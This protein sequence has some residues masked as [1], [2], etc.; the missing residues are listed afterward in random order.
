MSQYVDA[1]RLNEAGPELSD[2]P[3]G[4]DPHV[5]PVAVAPVSRLRSPIMEH[6]L[7]TPLPVDEDRPAIL[8]PPLRAFL[9]PSAL[10][11]L[12]GA[13]VLLLAGWQLGILAAIA[14]PIV[15]EVEHRSA[16]ANFS[17]GEGF[18][19]YKSDLGWPQGVQEDDDVHWHWSRANEG[20]AARG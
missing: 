3:D 8:L 16:R 2:R 12:V 1:P 11:L 17:L 9:G 10:A 13:P 20:G 19:P 18:L 7:V 5:T 6:R 15:R 14:A 4:P